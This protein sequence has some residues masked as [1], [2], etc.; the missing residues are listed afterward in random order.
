[1]HSDHLPGP[2]MNTRSFTAKQMGIPT[3]SRSQ[4]YYENLKPEMESDIEDPEESIKMDTP[5]STEEKENLQKQDFCGKMYH[6]STDPV[7]FAFL[8][9][10]VFP[11]IDT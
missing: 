2:R 1:M 10:M 3:D 9:H 5:E 11:I 6:A 7:S 8:Q 4:T